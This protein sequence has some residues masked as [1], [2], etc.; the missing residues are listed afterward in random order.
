[1]KTTPM[2]PIQGA[3][4]RSKRRVP[5]RDKGIEPTDE[6]HATGDYLLDKRVIDALEAARG[7]HPLVIRHAIPQE[8]L[9]QIAAAWSDFIDEDEEEYD[10]NEGP[11]TDSDKGSSCRGPQRLKRAWDEPWRVETNLKKQNEP[12]TTKRARRSD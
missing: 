1:M 11:K 8:A 3:K 7:R 9:P 2:L 10:T 4:D 12:T 6:V 5:A